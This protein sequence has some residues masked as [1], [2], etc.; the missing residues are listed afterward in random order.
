MVKKKVEK[1]IQI[2][3]LEAQRSTRIALIAIGFSMVAVAIP[4]YIDLSQLGDLGKAIFVIAY[5]SFGAYIMVTE[6]E[7]LYKLKKDIKKL[8]KKTKKQG[9]KKYNNK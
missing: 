4:T 5:I 9:Y 8:T 2:L 3:I 6:I 7:R 1:D